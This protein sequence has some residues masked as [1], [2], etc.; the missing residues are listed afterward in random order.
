MWDRFGR[1]L[2]LAIAAA[3]VA[4]AGTGARAETAASDPKAVAIADKVMTALG[5]QKAWKGARFLR[6]DF[7]VDREGKALFSR[8]HTWDKWNGRYRLE[9]TTKKGDPLVVLMNLNTKDGDAW[10]KGKKLEGKEEKKQLDEA[11]GAWTNDTYWLL[12]PYKLRD[13]GV[14]LALAGEAKEDGKTWDKLLLSFDNV[15][16]T[17]KDRYWVYVNRGSGL[18]DRWDFVLKG[19]KKPPSTFTWEGWKAYGKIK[20]PNDHVNAKDKVRIH[21]PVLD[22][23]ASVADSI[24]TT[25]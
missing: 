25:P 15:G 19:E 24:F 21:H 18:V 16:L 2:S 9:S 22:A 23:P 5:G 3:L 17:P 6:F 14:N 11:F 13:P 7:A 20:L 10:L 12:M 8:S 4:G 1:V